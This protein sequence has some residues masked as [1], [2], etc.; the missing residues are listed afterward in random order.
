MENK[1]EYPEVHRDGGVLLDHE[2]DGIQEYDNPVPGWLTNLFIVT[3]LYSLV[4]VILYPSWIGWEGT[5]SWSQEHQYE[6]EVA[7]AEKRWPELANREQI[8]FTEPLGLSPEE[9]EVLGKETYVKHCAS[10]HKE[11]GTGDIGPNLTDSEWIWGS[12]T[13]DVT[14][15]VAKGRMGEMGAM[16]PW[17]KILPKA[18]L[19]SVVYYVR[20]DLGKLDDDNESEN[21]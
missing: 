12:S 15:T 21:P 13:E 18:D 9:M 19:A 7:A 5:E 17:S 20:S 4:Y 1:S 16:P 11:D 10:C 6:E 3:I 8:D 14:I 2:Y